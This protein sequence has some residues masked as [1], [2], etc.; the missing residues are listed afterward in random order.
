MRRWLIVLVA[1]VLAAGLFAWPAAS[2]NWRRESESRSVIQGG[3]WSLSHIGSQLH[4]AGKVQIGDKSCATCT[5]RVDH[6]GAL[7]N[8]P[9]ISGAIRAWR[10]S[11]CGTT[12][13]TAVV[14]NADRRDLYLRNITSTGPSAADGAN[15]FIGFGT[16][17][18]V[19]LTASNGWVLHA[20]AH[21]ASNTLV[22][23]NYQGPVSCIG[24]T[25]GSS[26]SILEI[27]R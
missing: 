22:L 19:A 26:L 4:V 15:I 20:A 5:A 14:T 16:T 27:L 6:Y 3:D 10:V 24:T 1:A 25:A 18:H 9:H 2:Q 13:A 8:Q 7:A 23:P 21:M 11:Q 17:G 12:A